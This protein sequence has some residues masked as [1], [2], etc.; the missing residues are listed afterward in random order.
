MNVNFRVSARVIAQLGAELISSDEVAIFELVKNGFDAGSKSVEVSIWFRAS[1]TIISHL[2]QPLIEEAKKH[3][4]ASECPVFVRNC[5][6][7]RISEIPEIAKGHFCIM[8]PHDIQRLAEVVTECRDLRSAI[9]AIGKVNSIEV[10]D[11]GTGMSGNDV[12]QYYLT[13]GTT[14]RLRQVEAIQRQNGSQD[15][16]A[17]EK[18]IGRL[19]AMRLG[20]ELE[21]LTITAK[22]DS[23]IHL[24]INWREFLFR[25][26]DEL[27]TVPVHYEAKPGNNDPSGTLITISDLA[28]DW[29]RHK[30][31]KLGSDHLAKFIDPFPPLGNSGSTESI[32]KQII[33][34]WNGEMIDT[35][36]L[37]S[38]YLEAAQN[39]ARCH[40]CFSDTGAAQIESEFYY[41][42]IRTRAASTVKRKYTIA[43]F[44]NFTNGQLR[45]LG[46]FEFALYHFP[47]N[48]L[49]AIPQFAARSEVKSWLD[50]WSGGLMVFRDRVRVLPYAE[51]G[52][53]WLSLDAEALRGRGFR[54]NRIQVVGFVRVSRILNPLLIDQTNREG[55]QDNGVFQT[56]R[57]LLVRHIQENFVSGL[58]AH[59]SLEKADFEQL[60]QSVSH[61][62]NALNDCAT[63]LQR[64]TKEKDWEMAKEGV[65]K[66]RVVLSDL[67]ELNDAVEKALSEKDG[68]RVQVLELA[69]TGMSAESMAHD[70][71]GVIES[72][73]SS[74]SEAA[75]QSIDN[76]VGAAVRHIRAVHKALLIQLKQI[77]PGPA[78]SRRRASTFDLNAVI[79]ESSS[80]YKERL[81]RH[82]VRL[83][84]P[85]S[86]ATCMVHAVNGHV[87]QIV[88]N[89][90]RNSIYW[91][92]DTQRRFP[93][94]N[95]AWISVAID[96]RTRTLTFADS[97]IG[98]AEEDI[99]WVFKPFNSRRE[100]GRGL[101]LYICRELSDFNNIRISLDRSN[102]NRWGRTSHF[103]LEF[104]EKGGKL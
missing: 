29:P 7:Q 67:G 33:L 22:S 54:V 32:G 79:H 55:L 101:G 3:G 19:S 8:S 100:D 16:P 43:D 26:D 9:R 84:L 70:L 78:R 31:E 63:T 99:E 69:A 64:A 97:G 42:E 60:G 92:L 80:F 68:N 65:E 39:A 25:R 73:I 77:S 10:L 49:K 34:K 57:K 28:F 51:P 47:R 30:T 27:Q 53:D 18:G 93:V 50:R 98:V 91:V 104:V 40:V 76:R 41:G 36:E 23:A 44:S 6:L 56:F 74:L 17:G 46:P 95:D 102:R 83:T 35:K 52:D 2:Q 88:D 61:E 87:R 48:R 5:V 103:T 1:V 86:S 59:L 38:R 11:G 81:K 24:G 14:H 66:L 62:Y 85:D 96:S 82:G 4:F 90:F 94:E 21:M 58:D 71:E 13:I 72:A 37:I 89:L 15:V 75:L 45:D 20:S 12:Q